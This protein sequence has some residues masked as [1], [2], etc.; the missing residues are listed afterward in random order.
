MNYMIYK[1]Y[2][3]KG[4]IL[5]ELCT[6]SHLISLYVIIFNLL[7]FFKYHLYFLPTAFVVQVLKKLSVNSRFIYPVAYLSYLFGI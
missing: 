2:L 6:L 1:L 7:I 3:N 4:I 5:K